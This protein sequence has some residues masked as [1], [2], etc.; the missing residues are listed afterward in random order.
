MIGVTREV[1]RMMCISIV[2][3]AVLPCIGCGSKKKKEEKVLKNLYGYAY[4][5]DGYYVDNGRYPEKLSMLTTPMAYVMREATDPYTE[6]PYRYQSFG[7]NVALVWS[8]G[9][10]G[11]FKEEL[12]KDISRHTPEKTNTVPLDEFRKYAHHPKSNPEGDFFLLVCKTAAFRDTGTLDFW[13]DDIEKI[14]GKPTPGGTAMSTIS[15]KTLG[16][17][18]IDLEF[19]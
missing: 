13:K 10:D 6:K 19:N 4:A 17:N 12:L 18:G 11:T 2:L 5:L 14:L 3:A 16:R 15:G 7:K 9:A 1:M 8:P